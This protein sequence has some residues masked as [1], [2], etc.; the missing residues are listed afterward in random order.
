MVILINYQFGPNNLRSILQDISFTYIP[1]FI[2]SSSEFFF[3]WS[4]L[5]SHGPDREYSFNLHPQQSQMNDT[6]TRG[7]DKPPGDLIN[8]KYLRDSRIHPVLHCT[9]HTDIVPRLV[10]RNMY[11]WCIEQPSTAWPCSLRAST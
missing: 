10:R 5:P 11:L 7:V 4:Q 8:I 9:T 1:L 2:I 3:L 6:T